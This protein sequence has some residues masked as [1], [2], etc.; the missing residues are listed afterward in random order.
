MKS[1]IYSC[2]SCPSDNIPKFLMLHKDLLIRYAERFDIEFEIQDI[3]HKQYNPP[4]FTVYEAYKDFAESDYENMLY[5]DWDVMLSLGS[6]NIFEEYRDVDFAAYNWK[7][8]FTDQHIKIK[9][10]E[11]FNEYV[12]QDNLDGKDNILLPMFVENI[13]LHKPDINFLEWYVNEAIS[14]GIMLFRRDTMNN[15]LNGSGVS[16][17]DIYNRIEQMRSSEF[18]DNK[19]LLSVGGVLSHFAINYLLYYNNIKITNLNKKWN[20][21]SV[22]GMMKPDEYFYNFNCGG[23]E[24]INGA[25]FTEKDTAALNYVMNNKSRFFGNEDIYRSFISQY[26][27]R[28]ILA[29][30]QKH[31]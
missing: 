30:K 29:S 23:D 31:N 12:T 1:I 5:I 19:K 7:S 8:G 20:T 15:F 9:T 17:C 14:G 28:S 27:Y 4:V 2:Y 18:S 6:P 26:D 22:T 13:C 3:K 10:I 25:K 11:D 21:N 16:W 24:V